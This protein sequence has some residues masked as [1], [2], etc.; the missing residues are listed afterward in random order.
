MRFALHQRRVSKSLQQSNETHQQQQVILRNATTALTT[1][2]LMSSLA[3]TSWRE[4]SGPFSYS[5]I[6]ASVAILY[7]AFFMIAGVLSNQVANAGPAV[8]SKSHHCGVWNQSYYDIAA[9]GPNPESED[10][11][12]LSVQYLTKTN[13]NVQLSLEY[14]QECYMSQPPDYMSSTCDTMPKPALNWTSNATSCPFQPHMCNKHSDA[15]DLDTGVI[16]SHH[17]L[18]INAKQKDRLTYR[19]TTT[20]AVLDDDGHVQ[21]WN[22]TDAQATAYAYYGSSLVEFTDWTYSYSNYA[23]A[24]TNFTPQATVPYQV[25][26]QMAYGESPTSDDLNNFVPLEEFDQGDS[27]LNLMFLSYTGYYVKEIDDPWV[28]GNSVSRG[29]W[30]CAGRS[31]LNGRAIDQSAPSPARR[32][33][34]SVPMTGSA[35]RFWAG[36][37]FRMSTISILH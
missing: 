33:T 5:I 4:T 18:G 1:L 37:K 7:A 25:N 9:F 24:F 12:T 3:W 10:S 28:L 32:G 6:V 14:A 30:C 34:S 21:D 23:S 15:V 16:D 35:H 36:D 20:C 17:D 27:D 13:H 2:R 8:L 31:E 22:D 26:G 19:R 29:R 11:L